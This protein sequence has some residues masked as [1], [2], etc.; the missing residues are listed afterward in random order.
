ML[1]CLDLYHLQ[2]DEWYLQNL[3]R[4]LLPLHERTLQYYGDEFPSWT[5]SEVLLIVKPL[6][7]LRAEK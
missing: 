5:V 2:E 3:P 1:E 4:G 7:G 6:L